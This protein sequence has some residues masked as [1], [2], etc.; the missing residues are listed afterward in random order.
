MDLF[1]RKR[2]EAAV[3]EMR[4]TRETYDAKIRELGDSILTW[5]DVTKSYSGN[6]YKDY[7][8]ATRAIHEKYLGAA[9]WGV[10]LVGNIVDF[11]SAVIIGDGLQTRAIAS[12]EQTEQGKTKEFLPPALLKN[13]IAKKDPPPSVSDI[14]KNELDFA[15]RFF[16]DN[17]LDRE[18]PQK[19]AK[20]AFMDGKILVRLDWD[21]ARESVRARVVPYILKNYKVKTAADDYENFE[22]VSWRDDTGNPVNLN[23]GVFVYRQFGGEIANP[24]LTPHKLHRCLTQV[25]YLDRAITD[26]RKI[27]NLYA[28]PTPDIQCETEDQAQA[29]DQKIGSKKVNFKIGKIFI[30]TGV[31]S[32]KGI[33]MEGI[34]CLEKEIQNLAKMIWG[35]SVCPFSSSA[36]PISS[37]TAR[38]PRT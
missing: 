32:Y 5:L 19:W 1:N 27:D 35:P 8:E 34:E 7:G 23:A 14:A 30:H 37:R 21:A 3:K 29:I 9:D 10:V 12:V 17:R 2:L 16:K 22:S 36:F 33:P 25:D 6:L 18:A 20:E 26:W 24:N 31:F 4:A 38:L 28:S 13:K 15:S 11:M